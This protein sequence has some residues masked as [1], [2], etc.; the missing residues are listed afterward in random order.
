MCSKRA[1]IR[2]GRFD[3]H[4]AVPLP[5]IRGRA[6]ILV[7]HMKEIVVSPDVDPMILARGTPGFSGADL[8]NMVKYALPTFPPFFS[9][10]DACR[11]SQAA[12]QASKELCKAVDLRHLEW[13]K[14]CTVS[15]IAIGFELNFFWAYRTA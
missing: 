1:L 11:L 3:R 2:P 13:A 6:Q 7:H 8:Q 5:D 15:H 4:I 9:V 10:I 12:I 14:V